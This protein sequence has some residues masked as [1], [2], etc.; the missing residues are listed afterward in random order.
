MYRKL[1]G[2]MASLG[3]V[4]ALFLSSHAAKASEPTG[5]A[6]TIPVHETQPVE[7]SLFNANVEQL[8]FKLVNEERAKAGLPALEYNTVLETYARIKSQDMGDRNYFGHPDPEGQLMQS[9]LDADGIQY[10]VWG[11][12][13]AMVGGYE[14][15]DEAL[16]QMFL[17]NWMNSEG[18]RANILSPDFEQIGIG[19]YQVGNRIYATQEFM[20]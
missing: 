9:Q 7:E 5:V 20:K 10:V 13:L 14:L 15:D 11:E 16:A 6:A 17:N 18:H 4:S 3:L 2:F 12:N 8:I 1:L 19:V